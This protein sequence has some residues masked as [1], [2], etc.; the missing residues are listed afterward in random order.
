MG[1]E[2]KEKTLHYIYKVSF[3]FEKSVDISKQKIEK[4]L[5]Y[6]TG[7][8]TAHSH[9]NWG[10]FVQIFNLT[11]D[12]VAY[13][14]KY[15]KSGKAHREAEVAV[16]EKTNNDSWNQGKAMQRSRS[17]CHEQTK[18]FSTAGGAHVATISK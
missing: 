2:Q 5:K 12:Q 15:N 16:T 18:R 7:D 14:S 8:S 10:P 4:Q 9:S 1:L 13:H 3:G 6:F 17:L 11:G